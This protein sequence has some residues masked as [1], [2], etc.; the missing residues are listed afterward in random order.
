MDRSLR[1]HWFSTGI[2]DPGEFFGTALDPAQFPN[3]FPDSNSY[4]WKVAGHFNDQAASTC[5]TDS[6]SDQSD[7]PYATVLMCRATFVITD[8]APTDLG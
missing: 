4:E 2:I 3:D 1:R 5:R 7:E 6:G 8:L